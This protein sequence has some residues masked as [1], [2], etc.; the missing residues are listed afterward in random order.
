MKDM[1]DVFRPEDYLHY[2][3]EPDHEDKFSLQFWSKHIQRLPPDVRVLEYGGG[4]ALYSVLTLAH[5]AAAIHFSDYVPANLDAVRAWIKGA[6]D[7]FNWNAYTQVILELQDMPGD[8]AAIAQRE[9]KLRRAITHISEGDA[10]TTEMLVDAQP[11]YDVI[12]AHHC[13]DVAARDLP[14]FKRMLRTLSAMLA[15]GG[16]FLLSVTT[17]TTDYTV[18][19]TVFPCLDL[20]EAEV[21]AALIEAG[22]AAEYIERAAMPV[23]RA[24]YSGVLLH[25]A[26]KK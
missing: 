24:E 1:R 20:S 11:P 12:G 16:L 19:H 17:G 21:Q 15:D 26:W 4:P 2:F 3:D 5:K 10:R 14:D 6:P 8:V 25:A 23:E 18:D 13:L 22:F 7:A 9:A